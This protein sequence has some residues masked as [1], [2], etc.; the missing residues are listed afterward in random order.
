MPLEV[1]DGERCFLDAN[2]LYYCYVETPPLSEACRDLMR[3]VQNGGVAAF[4]AYPETK[5]G[6][7]KQ[8][9]ML[10]GMSPLLRS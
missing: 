4:R 9:L 6:E 10:A 7:F 1:P 8:L 2:I 5:H 3:R